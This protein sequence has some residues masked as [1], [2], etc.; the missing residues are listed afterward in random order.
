MAQFGGQ[1]SSKERYQRAKDTLKIHDPRILELIKEYQDV[2]MAN[3]WDIG[4]TSLI[5]HQIKTRGDPI[6]IKPRRQPVNLEEKI[7]TAIQN[8]WENN[9]IKKCNSPWNTPLVCVWLLEKK[10]IRLCL[11][12]RQLNAVT[13]RQAFSMPN[14]AEMLDKLNGAKYFSSIDLGNAYYQV[15]LEEESKKKTA[16]STKMGQF[17]FNRMPFGIAAAPG[18]FQELMMKVLG[19]IDGTAVYL[20]DILVFTESIEQHYKTLGEV[21]ERIKKAGLRINPEKCHI[22][23]KELKFLGH[24]INSRGIQTD[25]SKTE[26]IRSFQMPKCIKNLRSFLGICNYYRRF[27]KGYAEKSRALEELCGRN[28]EKKLVWTEKCEKAF[29]DM[30]KAL[31]TSP[32]LGFPDFRKEFILDTD[33]SFDTI[34]AVLSQLDDDG[35]ERVIAY[36]SHA[37]SNHEKGYC[38]TRKELLAIY[39]FCQYFNHYLYGRRFTLRTDHKAITFMMSTKKPITAQFQTWINLLSSYDIKMEYRKGSNHSNADM[40]SRNRCG[41]CTQCLTDHENP[42]EGKMKTRRINVLDTNGESQW[43]INNEEVRKIKDEI[44]RGASWKFTMEN[45]IL[46]H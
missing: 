29:H 41:T 7:D 12:F 35:Y 33:A 4:C 28:K 21:L 45:G 6:N 2:F 9:I 23:R 16:F 3:S 43:Q 5:K 31:T 37:M 32:I 17:C 44:G 26:A 19:N 25:P 39:Y 11:D 27:I 34:G 46:K 42:K 1:I 40:L 22:L 24:I 30:K 38:I 20:D 13:E 18:T 15:E 10:D 14:I 8:L 36:G